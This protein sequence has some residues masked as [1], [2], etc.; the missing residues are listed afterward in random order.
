VNDR[1]GVF[2]TPRRSLK[3]W[4][5]DASP[6]IALVLTLVVTSTTRLGAVSFR[7]LIVAGLIASVGAVSAVLLA[8]GRRH[9]R[10]E[11]RLYAE[12]SQMAIIARE[13]RE[14]DRLSIRQLDA[15]RRI[16]AGEVEPEVGGSEE[17]VDLQRRLE[18]LRKIVEVL[19]QGQEPVELRTRAADQ[20]DA[21]ANQM[22]DLAIPA[23]GRQDET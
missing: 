17:W 15:L 22:A 21:T 7:P 12:A 11:E 8:L 6:L 16:L 4:I 5:T 13:L 20:L 18:E 19:A 2:L 1:L 3:D 10:K 14:Q 9:F 23:P